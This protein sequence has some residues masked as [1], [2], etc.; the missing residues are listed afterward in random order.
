MVFITKQFIWQA[1]KVQCL[2][3]KKTV[4]AHRNFKNQNN[5]KNLFL[6]AIYVCIQLI[7]SRA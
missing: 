7:N 2:I 1:G 4:R 6:I 3:A 5:Q